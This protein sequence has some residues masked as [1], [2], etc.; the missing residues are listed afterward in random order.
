MKRELYTTENESG[1]MRKAEIIKHKIQEKERKSE[2]SD[3]MKQLYKKVM[4]QIRYTKYGVT[5]SI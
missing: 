1:E 2:I 5:S 4:A 3:R